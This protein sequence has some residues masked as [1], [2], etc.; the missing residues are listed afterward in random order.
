MPIPKTAEDAAL[1]LAPAH[2]QFGLSSA[3]FSH[4]Q[5]RGVRFALGVEAGMTHIN[6]HSVDDSRSGR[7]WRRKEQWSWALRW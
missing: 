5:D 6:D 3:V 2:L 4:D 1:S 7:L